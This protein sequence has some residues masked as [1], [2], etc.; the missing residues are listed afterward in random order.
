MMESQASGKSRGKGPF[1]SLR[2]LEVKRQLGPARCESLVRGGSPSQE[3]S[4]RRQ[5]T[6]GGH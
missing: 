6:G 2:A 5:Q 1:M 4:A 3:A